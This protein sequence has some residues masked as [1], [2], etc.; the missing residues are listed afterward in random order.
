MRSLVLR[1]IH[2][3]NLQGPLCC[4]SYE[5]D[6]LRI[7]FLSFFFLFLRSYKVPALAISII[8]LLALKREFGL[9]YDVD[10][11]FHLYGECYLKD[12]MLSK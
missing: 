3:S 12:H 4:W 1:D 9:Y 11:L 6:E 2:G 7:Y 10:L 5:S 8:R